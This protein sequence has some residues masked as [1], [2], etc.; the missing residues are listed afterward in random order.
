MA[1]DRIE[2]PGSKKT[3]VEGAA[4]VAKNPLRNDKVWL[5][6][7]VHV[8]AHLLDRVANVGTDEGDVLK[9]PD[10]ASIEHHVADQD[11]SS[12]ETFA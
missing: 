8:K 2:N 3:I 11:A 5:P 1:L 7:S 9:S 10:K 12:S 4:E 6:R